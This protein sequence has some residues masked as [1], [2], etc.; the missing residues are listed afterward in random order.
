MSSNLNFNFPDYISEERSIDDEEYERDIQ[1][2]RKAHDIEVKKANQELKTRC[3]QLAPIME[4]MG[5]MLIDLAPHVAMVGSNLFQPCTNT[6]SGIS[7][8][9]IDGSQMSQ[10][11]HN[12]PIQ[13]LLHP[14]NNGPSSLG[15]RTISAFT[16][17][18]GNNN[19]NLNTNDLSSGGRTLDFE[20]PVML[21]PGELLSV[22]PRQD[23]LVGDGNVHLHLNAQ[24]HLPGTTTL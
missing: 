7:M 10:N 18:V 11:I 21:N 15:R 22:T 14:Q 16:N 5:R 12:D 13:R 3:A 19:P 9:T 8:H 4:R 20:I 2:E 23:N 6:V 1:R 24:V 17:M